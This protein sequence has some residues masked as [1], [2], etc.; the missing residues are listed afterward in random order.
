MAANDGV[1]QSDESKGSSLLY[2]RLIY[3]YETILENILFSK[4]NIVIP[5]SNPSLICIYVIALYFSV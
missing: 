4:D 3:G 5:S 1:I 2:L